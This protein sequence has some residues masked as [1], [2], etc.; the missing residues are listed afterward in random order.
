MAKLLENRLVKDYGRGYGY[1]GYRHTFS[2]GVA[3]PRQNGRVLVFFEQLNHHARQSAI[4]DLIRK[5][6]SR[7]K[8]GH[9][10]LHSSHHKR[11][12]NL[13]ILS[14][15]EADQSRACNI[16]KLIKG[17]HT[18][19]S[20]LGKLENILK[21][22]IMAK[23]FSLGVYPEPEPVSHSS[24]SG[25]HISSPSIR[26]LV[27]PDIHGNCEFYQDREFLDDDWIVTSGLR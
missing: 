7:T 27:D 17:R 4:L 18:L 14:M 10:P 11:A 22:C 12:I 26:S 25:P 13:L 20:E 21:V 6:P 19:T 23:G 2:S 8:N 24:R 5:I 9:A 1:R 16:S 15:L 3:A